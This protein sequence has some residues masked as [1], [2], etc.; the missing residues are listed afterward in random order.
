MLSQNY[1]LIIIDYK[2]K[3]L[4]VQITFESVLMY[5]HF[6]RVCFESDFIHFQ[7]NQTHPNT[8]W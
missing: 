6:L 8:V 5:L 4:I 3:K 7:V 2:C 1:Y